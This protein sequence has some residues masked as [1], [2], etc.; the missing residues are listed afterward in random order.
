MT[1]SRYSGPGRLSQAELPLR[2]F[3]DFSG[4]ILPRRLFKKGWHYCLDW[5]GMLLVPGDIEMQVCTCG[6]FG[7]NITGGA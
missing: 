6:V 1:F 2:V 4:V 3:Y 5:D 7:E